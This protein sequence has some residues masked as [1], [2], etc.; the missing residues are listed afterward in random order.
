MPWQVA[1]SLLI[2]GGAFNAA[3]GLMWAAQRL[4]YGEDKLIMK[5]DWKFNMHERHNRVLE[6]RAAM[7]KA[8]QG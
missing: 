8:N 6:Y 7:K 1:P 4:G 5:D 2:I 3:A